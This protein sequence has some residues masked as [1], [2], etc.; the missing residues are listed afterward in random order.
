MFKIFPLKKPEKF[1]VLFPLSDFFDAVKSDPL[2]FLV[3]FCFSF[4]PRT[5]AFFSISDLPLPI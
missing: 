5:W 3:F 2:Y 1:F 4:F